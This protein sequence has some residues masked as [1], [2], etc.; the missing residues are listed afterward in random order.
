MIGLETVKVGSFSFNHYAFGCVLD[1][2]VR[3]TVGLKTLAPGFSKIEIS[4][5]VEIAEEF[6]FEYIS[7]S[8]MI[9]IVKNGQKWQI[10]TE[11]N[12]EVVV[13]LSKVQGQ[14]VN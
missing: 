8:G 5:S 4:P 1:W 7:H 10:K 14:L 11:K 6:E 9:S 12:I 2:M 3:E 13:N